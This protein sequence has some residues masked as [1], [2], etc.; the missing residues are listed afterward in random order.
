MAPN[1]TS[2]TTSTNEKNKAPDVQ[3][4]LLRTEPPE[5]PS[6]FT[7]DQVLLKLSFQAGILS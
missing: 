7:H 2:L 3:P 4:Q 1:K 6:T 5:N